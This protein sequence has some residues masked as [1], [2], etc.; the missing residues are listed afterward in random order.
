MDELKNVSKMSKE[1]CFI[2]TLQLQFKYKFKRRDNR[3][4]LNSGKYVNSDISVA[5]NVTLTIKVY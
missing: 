4:V 2:L 1:Y 5:S 3:K